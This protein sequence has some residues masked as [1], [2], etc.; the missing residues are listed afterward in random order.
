M[1]YAV[2]FGSLFD[3]V[4]KIEIIKAPSRVEALV[5]HSSLRGWE[6]K[7]RMKEKDLEALVHDCDAV[8]GCVEVS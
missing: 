4:M 7:P 5:E 1:K 3:N 6:V 8:I 2:A